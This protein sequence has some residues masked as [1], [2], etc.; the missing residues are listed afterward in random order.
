VPADPVPLTGVGPARPRRPDRT[1]LGD[2]IQRLRGLDGVEAPVVVACSGGADSLALLAFAVVLGLEPVAVHVEHGIRTGAAAEPA[3]VASYA[4][5]LGA[6]FRPERVSVEPGPNLEARA[7]AVRYG[8][9]ERARVACGATVVLVG[10]TA[11][12]Q[13]ETVLLNLLRGSASGGLGAMAT[14]RGTVVRPMLDLR[15]ADSEAVCAVLGLEPLADPMNDDRA[16]RRVWIRRE[17]L[18]L[19]AEGAGRDLVPVLARQ[20]EI[21]RS[22]ADEL[23]RQAAA[24]W[25]G[26]A[27]SSARALAAL[28]PVLA[29]RAVRLWVGHP[30]PSFAEVERVLA[31]ARGGARAAQLAGGRTVVRRGGELVLEETGEPGGEE[32]GLGTRG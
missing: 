21:L 23:D 24:A 4:E 12:D 29:R 20:A 8:A 13:A 3:L 28:A 2:R 17:V 16:L 19:L 6:G 26:T 5:G 25:P 10:H 30:R 18:P 1:L 22:E 27:R 32:S 31:V 11:D 15:R 14:R 9:L 7:R